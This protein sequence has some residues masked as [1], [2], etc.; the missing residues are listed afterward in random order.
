MASKMCF[1]NFDEQALRELIH[2]V[3][4]LYQT[5]FGDTPCAVES[6][7]SEPVKTAKKRRTTSSAPNPQP[8]ITQN[9]FELLSD[10]E[11]E[12]EEMEE[13]VVEEINEPTPT[14][15]VQPSTSGRNKSEGTTAAKPVRKQKIAPIIIK[16]TAKWTRTANLMREKRITATKSKLINTGIQVEPATEEDYR[17]LSKLLKEQKTQFYTYQLKSEKKLKVVLRGITQDI[18]DDEIKQDLQA[19]DYPVEKITRMKGKQG[20]PSPLVLVEID[21][22]YKSIYNITDCCGLAVKVQALRTRNLIVQCHKCQM[23][24]HTQSNCNINYKCMKC[25]EHHSTHLCEKPKTTPP[26]C[27]NCGGEHLSTYLKCP[28]N[29]NNAVGKKYIDAP[30]PKNNPWTKKKDNGPSNTQPPKEEPKKTTNNKTEDKLALILGRMLLRHRRAAHGV[31][32]PNGGTNSSLQK[33]HTARGIVEIHSCYGPPGSVLSEADFR[34]VFGA[35][36]PTTLA[37]DLNCPEEDTHIHIPT[38]STDVLDIAVV[39]DVTTPYHLETVNDLTSDHLPVVMTL[40]LDKN[41]AA[42]TTHTT[43]WLEFEKQLDPRPIIIKRTSDIDDM[44]RQFEEDVKKAMAAATKVK[45]IS[46][47]KRIPD[48]IKD[49]SALWK[50][51]KALKPKSGKIPPLKSETGIINDPRDKTEE[52]ANYFEDTFLPNKPASN[53]LEKFANAING[54]ARTD[55]GDELD[56]PQTTAEELLDIIKTLKDRKAPGRDG[57]TN[58]A[59]KHL[60]LGAIDALRDIINGVLRYQHFPQTWKHAT[61]IVLHKTG[62][63]KNSTDGYRPISLLAGLSKVLEK[64][65]Q[66]RLLEVV[67]EKEILPRFQFGFRQEHSTTHQL[68][69]I[70]EHITEHLDRSTPTATN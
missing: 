52:F 59:I 1:D 55:Y 12:A 70:T 25:G 66:R 7:F 19:Q 60:H 28:E 44:V 54:L 56:P 5:K 48:H 27:A 10:N 15:T 17:K 18:T 23:F 40:S 34:A 26:K 47:R 43:S 33:I 69:R 36:H 39:K 49:Q 31:P 6:D 46:H 30:L 62:K 45:T 3:M 63:P 11:E 24:G 57:I 41:L 14:E 61:V 67:S 37:G 58:A 29:P 64:V 13:D 21:R 35:G 9:R 4:E 38:G 20:K 16:E 53:D 42:T 32:S 2:T 65:I 50:M 8:I 68:L 51:A 22:L